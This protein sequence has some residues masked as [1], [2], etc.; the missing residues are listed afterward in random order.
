VCHN[1]SHLLLWLLQVWLLDQPAQLV[2]LL[3]QQTVLLIPPAVVC[4]KP[5]ELRHLRSNSSGRGAE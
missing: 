4:C 1:C 5:D 2:Q 3:Q